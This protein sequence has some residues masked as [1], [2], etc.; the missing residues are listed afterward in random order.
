MSFEEGVKIMAEK[1]VDVGEFQQLFEI[2]IDRLESDLDQVK[3]KVDKVDATVN[4]TN[5]SLMFLQDS[6]VGLKTD[7][8][9]Y[10]DSTVTSK[11]LETTI[12]PINDKIKKLEEDVD[13]NK[14]ARIRLYG[15]FGAAMVLWPIIMYALQSFVAAN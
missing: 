6:I 1:K 2:F 8:K 3:I 14:T 7:L 10:K 4:S 15:A 5:T 13:V 12:T 9:E 11:D